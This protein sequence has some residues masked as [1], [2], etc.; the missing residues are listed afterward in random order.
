VRDAVAGISN[1]VLA[2]TLRGLEPEGLLARRV[3][4]TVPPKVEYSLTALGRRLARLLERVRGW[5]ERDVARVEKARRAYDERRA[6]G[7]SGK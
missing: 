4:A 2:R 5:A 1:R 3:H 7:R 6:E